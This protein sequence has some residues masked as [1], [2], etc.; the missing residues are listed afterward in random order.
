R[1]LIP[2]AFFAEAV[3]NVTGREPFATLTGVHMAKQRM[4]F[5]STKAEQELSYRSRP[6][7]EGIE[8]AVRW[9]R[10]AG[11]LGP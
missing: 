10:D 4:F 6:Y 8:D 7:V 5:V 2:V 3:A 11:Y 9:F 1:A